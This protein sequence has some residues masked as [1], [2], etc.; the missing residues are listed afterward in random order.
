MTV[1]TWRRW[2]ACRGRP[3]AIWYA[4]DSATKDVAIEVCRGCPVRQPCLVD[5]LEAE[6]HAY[7]RAHGVRGGLTGR[8]RNRLQEAEKQARYVPL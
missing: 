1:S 3:I 2:A 8:D 7:G 6:R 4:S 5:A